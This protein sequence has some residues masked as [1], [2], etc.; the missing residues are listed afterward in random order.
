MIIHW[1]N[2]S[3]QG[4]SSVLLPDGNILTAFGTGY[5][6]ELKYYPRDIGLVLWRLGEQPLNDDEVIRD[7]LFDSDVHN[8]VDPPTGKHGSAPG[9]TKILDTL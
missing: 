2:A 9:A 1:N 8:L 7:A 5:R 4:T 6:A 3:S